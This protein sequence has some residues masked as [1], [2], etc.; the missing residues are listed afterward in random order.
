MLLAMSHRVYRI[1]EN[2]LV[3]AHRGGG[4]EQPENSLEA[5]RAMR[6]AGFRHIESD[7]HSTADGVAVIMHDPALDRT[8]DGSGLVNE[9]TWAE[10][11]RVRDASGHRPPRLDEVL[12]AFPDVVFNLDAKADSS[13]GPLL[14]AVRRTNAAERVCLASFSQKRIERMRALLPEAAYSLGTTAIAGLV[15]ASWTGSAG[16]WQARRHGR[17]AGV[18]KD[19]AGIEAV[20]VPV[21]QPLPAGPRGFARRER[22]IRVITPRFVQLAHSLGLAVHAW[23]INSPSQAQWLVEMGVDGIITD[24]P[25]RTVKHLR[26]RGYAAEI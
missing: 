5:F 19:L 16:R 14:E 22:R 23:T 11:E 1:T 4:N 17:F 9:K 15:A 12:D 20:Q 2:P 8:T 24:E 6:E 25:T 3:I 13:V 18:P 7:V 26:A 10:I 21:S